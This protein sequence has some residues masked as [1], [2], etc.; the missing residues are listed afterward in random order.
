MSQRQRFEFGSFEPIGFAPQ[1]NSC[2]LSANQAV[3][4]ARRKGFDD[5]ALQLNAASLGSQPS[6]LGSVPS[7]WQGEGRRAFI[8]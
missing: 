8:H 2:H 3:D 1:F 6:V 4:H 5:A 7:Q